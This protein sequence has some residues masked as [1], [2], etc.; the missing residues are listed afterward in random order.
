MSLILNSKWKNPNDEA[1]Y[2][3]LNTEMEP[4]FQLQVDLICET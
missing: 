4:S 2:S 1:E 3:C